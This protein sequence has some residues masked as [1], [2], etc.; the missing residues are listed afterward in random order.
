MSST[1]AKSCLTILNCGV[2]IDRSVLV[3][4]KS[5]DIQ[6]QLQSVIG[7]S[8]V[9]VDSAREFFTSEKMIEL[10][11]EH[12]L[13]F[14]LIVQ[15]TGLHITGGEVQAIQTAARL[16]KEIAAKM[17]PKIPP[18]EFDTIPV[19]WSVKDYLIVGPMSV[20][21][22]KTNPNGDSSFYSL[23]LRQAEKLWLIASRRWSKLANANNT[24]R[25][26]AD[27]GTQY[28]TIQGEYV[29][30]GCQQVRRYELEQLALHMKWAFPEP[31]GA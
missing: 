30:V 31:K 23:S 5:G 9:V 19:G 4:L 21:R 27:G 11:I 29:D 17:A 12:D 25:V 1:P 8:I 14:E 26:A 20:S 7:R 16:H 18:Y 28:C 13:N 24:L 3:T 2:V 22:K 15:H 6:Q 10:I